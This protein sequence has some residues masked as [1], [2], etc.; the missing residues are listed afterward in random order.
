MKPNK[1]SGKHCPVWVAL[2]IILRTLTGAAG[3]EG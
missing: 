3:E 2:L 1:T